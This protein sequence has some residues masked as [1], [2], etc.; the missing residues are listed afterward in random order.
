VQA[1]DTSAIQ[2]L[3]G[4]AR[5]RIRSQWAL[6][7]ATT[8]SILA[9]AAAMVAIFAMRIE[10]VTTS[11]GIAMLF[12]SVA[13][14]LL[15]AVISASRRLD[16]ETVARRIDRASNLSDRLS[17]AI[18]FQRSL[19]TATSHD[20]T[21]DLMIAAIKD[22][23]RAVPRANII[24]A[25]PFRVP[26]DMNVAAGFF[27]VSALVAG[28][29]IERPDRTPSL[30][31]ADPAQARPG[32]IVHLR[33]KNLLTGVAAPI[34]SLD[35]TNALGAPGV[36]SAKKEPERGF[37]PADASVYLGVDSA[38][39]PVPVIDWAKDTIT[40]RI[41]DDAPIGL[42]VLTAYIGKKQLGPVQFEVLDLTDERG[43]KEG[44][45]QFPPDEKAYIESIIGQLKDA[46]QRDNVPELEEFAKKIEQLLKDAEQGKI[47]KEQL[48]DALAKAEEEL[49]KN[50]EPNQAEIDKA[51]QD[52][53]KELAKE[54]L[55]KELGQAL[56]KKDLQK[57]KEELEKLADKLDPEEA[58]KQLEEL[59]KQL[60]NKELTP[61]QKQDLQKQMEDLKKQM[62]N[63]NLTEQQKQDLQKQMEELKK[64]LENKNL[65]EQQKQELQ[66]KI[67][68]L[69]QNK[70]LS[71]QE[72]QKLQEKLEQVAKQMQQKDQSQQ[73]KS[74]QQMQKLQDEIKRLEK[75]KEQAKNDKEQQETERQL[76]KKK[77][78]LQKLQKDEQ[79][80]EDSAQRQALKR[81]QKDIE[82]AAENLDKPQKDPNKSE[83]E[84]DEEAKERQKQ[85]SRN[86][87]DA[88]RETGRVDQDQRKQAGQ[89]KM[90]SQM[91]DLRE[92]M[93]RAKQKGNKGPNDP[94]NKN[95]KN[96][97]FAQRAK[98]QKGQG[99][100]SWKPGQGGQ[101]QGKGPGQGQGQQP[102]GSEPG[103]GHDD[104][105]A[106]DPTG[107]SGNTKDQDLQGTQS[108]SGTS[109]RETILAAAQKGF[110]SVGYQKVYADYQRIVEE[111][112]RTEKLPSSYKYYVKRYFAKIHPST[113]PVSE[114]APAPQDKP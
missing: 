19:G 100:Q 22:G 70:T 77:D 8:A 65:S 95:G 75:K 78:E 23:V 15:G 30:G 37:V 35:A 61:Q 36:V 56:E 71:E 29:F 74:Q 80:K 17:T 52:M 63:K 24:A 53:G 79:N 72:K 60:E 76:Q 45:V 51:M 2:R 94:F 9:A 3:I 14:V 93:R 67:E 105:L 1:T 47:T 41:P 27:A 12:G 112:M 49:S 18:A 57:A 25:A 7:G 114:P 85:A 20:E 26:R 110:A 59:K 101:G 38:A 83:Q 39:R 31:Y 32:E 5:F 99:G 4:R 103:V 92:A 48:L 21:D 16:D 28:L 91:D 46:A 43:I 98:G 11:T 86:L 58:K 66:K 54:N 102:G 73:Q 82:K 62:E 81:L 50:S 68:Q 90:S 97:D 111:V 104:N 107:K 10:L 84:Q 96:Q 109:R 87:K 40:I 33:G 89:K 64:Q 34:A 55:T 69:E 6:E 108:R 88:A 13:I 106:G 44:S 113:A 42:T